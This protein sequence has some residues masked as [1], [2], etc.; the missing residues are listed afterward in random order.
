[1]DNIIIN[2]DEMQ[3]N[4]KEIYEL[5]L[6]YKNANQIN[7]VCNNEIL[8]LKRV[9]KEITEIL[10]NFY[11]GDIMRRFENRELG[12]AECFDKM[13]PKELKDNPYFTFED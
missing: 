7:E 5:S 1:M 12:L 6:K 13:Y 3:I 10:T 2:I 4:L 8:I 11:K 9:H